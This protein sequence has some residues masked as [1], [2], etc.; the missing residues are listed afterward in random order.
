M[1]GEKSMNEL[2]KK[3]ITIRILAVVFAVLLWLYANPIENKPFT[4]Q[5]SILNENTLKDREIMLEDHNFPSTV[6]ITVRGRTDR[7]A[8]LRDNDFYAALDFS[9]VSS[10][11]DS[12][13]EIDGPIYRGKE[14]GI[15]IV[16]VKN[17]KIKVNLEAIG[18]NPLKVDVV[19]TGKMIEGYKVAKS[20]VIP[21]IVQIEGKQS[22]VELVESVR[23]YV[24]INKLDRDKTYY[25]QTCK[26]YDKNNKEIT[27]LNKP[28]VE[29]KV[30]VA[31]EV[32]VI[33]VIKGI[34][35]KD[36]V[37]MD[38][39][40]K[41]K[42][43]RVA[44]TGAPELLAKITELYT[45]P[46]DIENLSKSSDIT[47]I[48]KLPDGVKLFEM[49]KEVTVN[50]TIEQL[51]EKGFTI[52]RSAIGINNIDFDN[53]LNYTIVPEKLDITVKGQRQVLDRINVIALKPNID[54]KGLA[55]GN[56]TVPLVVTLP[57]GVR[58]IQD[59]TVDITVE[60]R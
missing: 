25:K 60:T 3:D 48:L 36:H 35:A 4:V 2:L 21:D 46:V 20:T 8:N 51:S 33:P 54:V 56:H 37:H 17:R 45:E 29:V 27:G 34:P 38:S 41:V 10:H 47:A 19:A 6:E 12:E 7:I 32:P 30:E 14:E 42:P 13:L 52:D 9:K 11:Q 49:P 40:K 5:L 16:S 1:E 18:D 24:D 43:E 57:A 28:T 44:I 50:I 22:L 53:P 55:A 59:Y 58:L 23:V 26:L 31:K 15:T 39:L